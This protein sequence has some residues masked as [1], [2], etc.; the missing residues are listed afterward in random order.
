[1]KYLISPQC[2]IWERYG[3]LRYWAGYVFQHLKYKPIWTW[4]AIG[5]S[6]MLVIWKKNFWIWMSNFWKASLRIKITLIKHGSL[7]INHTCRYTEAH[8]QSISQLHTLCF[9]MESLK[10]GLCFFGGS[11][12]L[13][14]FTA[15]RLP[16]T[17]A[18]PRTL[19]RL[20]ILRGVTT[21]R[22]HFI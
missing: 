19:M 16:V 1:M 11:V 14:S 10:H 17:Y 7:S 18:W 12:C 22:N 2:S 4:N 20:S 15:A 13:T 5:N 9:L 3:L 21:S 6:K 8:I